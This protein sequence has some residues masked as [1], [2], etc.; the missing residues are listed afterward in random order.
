MKRFL[1]LGIPLLIVFLTACPE[2]TS[3]AVTK[4]TIN[5]FTATPSSLSAGGGSV[6]LSW[7]VKDATT[8]SIDGGVGAVTGTSK[9]VSVTST[10][11]FILTATN[12]SGSTTKSTTV[13]V[14]TGGD[15]TVISVDPPD[16]ATGVNSDAIITIA[17]SEKWI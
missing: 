14:G 12:A 10:T 6:T 8:L 5:S 3:P 16:G 13:S 15:T 1:L 7:D 4:P 2:P 11:T 9:D 17:F